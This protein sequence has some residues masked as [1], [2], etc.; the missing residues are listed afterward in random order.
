MEEEERERIEA[1][2]ARGARRSIGSGAR[3]LPPPPP[4]PLKA[5][6]QDTKEYEG[7]EMATMLMVVTTINVMAAAGSDLPGT[8]S[9]RGLPPTGGSPRGRRRPPA[10]TAPAICLREAA[11]VVAG[12]MEASSSCSLPPPPLPR[13]AARDWRGAGPDRLLRGPRPAAPTGPPPTPLRLSLPVSLPPSLP[14]SKS[15]SSLH[16]AAG[17][18]SSSSIPASISLLAPARGR[19]A[20]CPPPRLG[21]SHLLSPPPPEFVSAV[22]APGRRRRRLAPG[23]SWGRPLGVPGSQ[24]PPP[25]RSRAP[26]PRPGGCHLSGSD[27]GRSG[28]SRRASLQEGAARCRRLP[29]GAAE[30]PVPRWFTVGGEAA[31]RQ[32]HSYPIPSS[33][34]PQPKSYRPKSPRP[35]EVAGSNSPE[36]HNPSSPTARRVTGEAASPAWRREM[37]ATASSGRRRGGRVLRG[38]GCSIPVTKC[39]TTGLATFLLHQHWGHH[40]GQVAQAPRGMM[41]QWALHGARSGCHLSGFDQ[42]SFGIWVAA[43]LYGD[44][45]PGLLC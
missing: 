41:A 21:P 44:A 11:A 27:S 6:R 25:T 12:A 43:D 29:S 42:E 10:A 9:P 17:P 13:A 2:R 14:D 33:L 23:S 15:S 20:P 8:S 31:T 1:L 32:P 24:D 38:G 34:G 22:D 16:S 4:P 35:L 30:M 18:G 3:R 40:P 28:G 36:A 37:V 39:G 19:S 5:T 45:V 26:R 7:Q